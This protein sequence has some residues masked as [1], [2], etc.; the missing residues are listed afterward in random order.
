M[1]AATGQELWRKIHAFAKSTK[2]VSEQELFFS[3]WMLEVHSS[4]GCET[5]FKKVVRF[6]KLWPADFGKGFHLWSICLHEYVNKELA[7]PMFA[8]NLTLAPLRQRGIIQ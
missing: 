2:S 8:P 1:T 6:L 4:I 3:Y 5:C 7:K